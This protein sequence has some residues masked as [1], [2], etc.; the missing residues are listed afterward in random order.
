[1]HN[2]YSLETLSHL[3]NISI[4]IYITITLQWALQLLDVRNNPHNNNNN[5][6]YNNN[7]SS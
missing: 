1:M 3:N 6:Y 2:G 7:N 5:Y 4:V